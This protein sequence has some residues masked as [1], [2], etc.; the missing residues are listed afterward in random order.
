MPKLVYL[1]HSLVTNDPALPS[2]QRLFQDSRYQLCLSIWNLL[3]IGSASDLAQRKVRVA[4]LSSLKPLWLLDHVY[5]R[6]QEVK[7]YLWPRRFDTAAPEMLYVAPHLS[8]AEACARRPFEHIFPV[9]TFA[10]TLV[11]AK[12]GREWLRAPE[13]AQ[14]GAS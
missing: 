2:F 9:L 12:A 10:A 5:V 3:E 1:D 13:P 4:F 6:K 7:R 11:R 14:R 8:Q